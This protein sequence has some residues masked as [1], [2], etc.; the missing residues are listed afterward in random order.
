MEEIKDQNELLDLMIQP[1]FSVVN[2]KICHINAAGSSQLLETGA[3]IAEL[4]DTGKEEYAALCDGTLYLN[5]R[6]GGNSCGASVRRMGDADI[7][8]LEQDADQAELQAMALAARELRQPLSNVMTITDRLFPI[9]GRDEDPALQ[10]QVARINR[11]LYQMLRIIGNMSDAY[12]YSKD[13]GSG[14][15]TRDVAA[16]LEELFAGH[17]ELIQHTQ[18]SLNF[19]APKQ[20]IYCLVDDEKLERAVSNILSNAVKFS[21]PGDKIDAALIR[22]G[23]LLYLTVRDSG[24]G[25]APNLRA[26]VYSRYLREPGIED[27]RHGIGLGMVLIRSAATAHGGTVLIQQPEGTGTQITMTLQI[28]Q[29]NDTLV[30]SPVHCIDYAGERDHKL[31]ELSEAL[32][33]CVY[34]KENIN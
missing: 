5:L 34:R 32:P 11:G 20:P 30:R 25:I 16:L 9:S 29:S 21:R 12:R 15:Q 13:T 18:I 23:N 22:K 7:F 4:L 10:E 6:I 8:V 17:R 26:N 1:A 28:R 27:G 19:T 2:G 14:Q 33:I 3:D 24:S 31:I